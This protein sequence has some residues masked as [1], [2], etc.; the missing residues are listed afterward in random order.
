MRQISRFKKPLF[1]LDFNTNGRKFKFYS[2]ND[3]IDWAKQEQNKW[4]WI[5]KVSDRRVPL[6]LMDY[7]SHQLNEI[8][9][10]VESAQDVN[11]IEFLNAQAYVKEVYEGDVPALYHSSSPTGQT[12]LL[13]KESFGDSE[14]A[15][16]YA[17][18]LGI[19]N[20]IL[21]NT[22]HLKLINIVANP[23][24]IDVMTQIKNAHDVLRQTLQISD[25]IHSQQR[26][27]LNDGQTKLRRLETQTRSI[28]REA[29]RKFVWANWQNRQKMQRSVRDAIH[30]I[31]QT[32]QTYEQHMQ[33]RAAVNY[34]DEK[35]TDHT[36]M[37]SVTF[38]QLRKFLI[39]SAIFLFFSFVLISIFILEASKI[40]VLDCVEIA[41]NDVE[42]A[43]TFFATMFALLGT[44]LTCV[45]WATRILVR[46]YLTERSL[47][48]DADKRRVMTKTFLALLNEGALKD[49]DRLVVLNALF[50]PV[51]DVSKMDEGSTDIALPALIAKLMDQRLTK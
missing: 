5:K 24:V 48:R 13:I 25:Q 35:K 41:N 21:R 19:E 8:I 6:H 22:L 1:E 45:F 37:K 27:L 28:S 15:L 32:R 42:P 47:I 23:G 50:R 17:L 51:G 46:N 36:Q 4:N 40:N 38:N 11:S 16:T 34:W 44:I 2:H 18:L 39:I 29:I 33:I 43:P 30:R 31:E 7:I 49:E 14:A 12:I 9:K 20:I 10:F 26:H 3:L